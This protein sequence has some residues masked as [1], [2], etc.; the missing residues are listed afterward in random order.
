M[1]SRIAETSKEQSASIH[2]V[3][4]GLDQISA[5][6]QTNSATAEESA[7]TSEQL[8]RQAAT[9]KELVGAFQLRK[10]RRK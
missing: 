7:A 5:V 3:S 9:L 6:V 2:Q 1:V 8:S 10:D 4:I